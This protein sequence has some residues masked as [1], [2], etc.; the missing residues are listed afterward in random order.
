MKNILNLAP[1]PDKNY[2]DIHHD[3]LGTVNLSE[4]TLG[5]KNIK[6]TPQMTLEQLR[7]RNDDLRI[8]NSNI[9]DFMKKN[10]ETIPV[11]WK[12]KNLY[13]PFLG[14]RFYENTGLGSLRVPTIFTNYRNEFEFIM[15]EGPRFTDSLEIGIPY[16]KL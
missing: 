9:F 2:R 4:Q 7:N 1:T 13:I 6:F 14:T 10:P 16:I 15:W 11:K 12:K 8:L 5:L 3:S